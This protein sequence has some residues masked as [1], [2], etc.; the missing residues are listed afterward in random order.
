M[1]EAT[2]VLFNVIA[3]PGKNSLLIDTNLWRPEKYQAILCQYQEWARPPSP[4]PRF[5]NLK[6]DPVQGFSR[7]SGMVERPEPT[8]KHFLNEAQQQC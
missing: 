4:P 1:N 8:L 7:K 5:S 6:L 3:T 2:S